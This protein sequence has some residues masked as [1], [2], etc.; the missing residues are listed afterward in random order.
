MIKKEMKICLPIYKMVY[1]VL[2]MI[3]LSLVRGI[4]SVVEIGITLDTAAA[5]LAIVFCAETYEMEFRGK[6]WEIFRLYSIRAK[7]DAIYRRM[8][9]QTGYLCL[10]SYI[11][12]FFFYWQKPREMMQI[13]QVFLYGIYI[14]A[15]TA[16]ILFWGVLSMTFVNLFR[17]LWAGMGV[18]LFLW[19]FINS[20]AGE[21]ILGKLS[22]F[23]YVFRDTSKI[24]D[25]SW[26]WGQGLSLILVILLLMSVP[27]IIKK[28]G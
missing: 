6:R 27:Y 13:S 2:F 12:Y 19:L 1:S 23:S 20:K 25:W 7:A 11:G 24:Q 15:V 9:V 17:N 8:A 4:S 18:S 10:I 22:V 16:A 28:R 21:R 3:L 5:V 26:L 14:L